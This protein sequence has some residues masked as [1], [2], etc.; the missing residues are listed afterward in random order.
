MMKFQPKQFEREAT[1]PTHGSYTEHGGSLFADA[2]RVFWWGC[3]DCNEAQRQQ[4]IAD[5]QERE[6]KLRQER[7]EARLNEA[8]IPAAFRTR[9][10]SNFVASE[11]EQGHAL[12][13]ATDYANNFWAKHYRD[14]RSL[15]FAGNPGT[16]KSHLAIAIGLAVLSRGT[17]MY[18]DVMDVVRTVRAT[19]GRNSTTTEDDVL[20]LFGE[21]IDLLI[22]DEIGVQRGTEDEQVILFDI[23]NRRYRENKPTIL[24]TNLGGKALADFLGPRTIDRLREKAIFVPFRWDSHRGKLAL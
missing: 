24:I 8:G 12:H 3:P 23:L 6:S 18:R 13:V 19:W 11:P 5:E 1:C 22:I 10:L 7:L 14:G 2:S 16:G 4:D 21:Q 15:I 17:V 9:M 20:R